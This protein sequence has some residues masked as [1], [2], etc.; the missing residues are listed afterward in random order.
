MAPSAEPVDRPIGGVSGERHKGGLGRSTA[1]FAG[2]SLRRGHAISAA[3]GGAPERVIM[4][5]T[6]HKS[7]RTERGYI[8]AGH[9]F[10]DP[11]GRYLDL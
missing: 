6:G 8:E 7:T 10:E 5:T 4:A 2:H 1:D 3:R 11:S 9:V